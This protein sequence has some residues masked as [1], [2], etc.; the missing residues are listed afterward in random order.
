MTF[1]MTKE[2]YTKAKQY[3]MNIG[4]YEEFLNNGFSV[5]GFSLIEFANN[6]L[7]TKEKSDDI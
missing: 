5:D 4:K 7:S 3:L 2:G 1:H 6:L